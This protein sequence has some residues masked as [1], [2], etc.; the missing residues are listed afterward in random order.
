VYVDDIP[1]PKGCLYGAFIYSTHPHARI[2]GIKFRSS[3]AS[4]KVITVIDAKDIPS[5]GENIGS[6]FA[7]LGEEALFADSVSEFA[8]QNIGIVVL[9][10]HFNFLSFFL[11]FFLMKVVMLIHNFEG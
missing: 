9:L 1:A 11:S 4:Q 6:T 7:S 2:K 10:N 8:G 5:G 3:L